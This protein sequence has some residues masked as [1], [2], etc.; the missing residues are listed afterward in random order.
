MS[1]VIVRL[2]PALA[3]IRDRGYSAGMRR[4]WL[5][6]GCMSFALVV[7]AGCESPPTSSNATRLEFEVVHADL[8][9][10]ADACGMRGRIFAVGRDAAGLGLVLE[11]TVTGLTAAT[12]E[13]PLPPL[14]ACWQASDSSLFAVGKSLVME[15]NP[16]GEWR[17]HD[18]SERFEGQIELHDVEGWDDGGVIVAGSVDGRGA[19]FRS[20]DGAWSMVDLGEIS[21]PPLLSMT[22]DVE[23]TIYAVGSSGALRYPREGSLVQ[24][25]APTQRLTSVSS[26]GEEIVAVTYDGLILQRAGSELTSLNELGARFLCTTF[27]AD[28]TLWIAGEGGVII[29][30]SRS[31][32]ST[33]NATPQVAETP[34]ALDVN[35]LLAGRDGPWALAETTAGSQ[36][37][38][39]IGNE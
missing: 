13:V 24:L 35:A 22:I 6:L 8:P 30:H 1:L 33:L 9:P 7:C 20:D 28:G 15:R 37:W 5:F 31:R 2:V 11:E 38:R 18:L 29:R 14:R 3:S 34:E 10:L 39:L 4:W 32:T 36:I 26:F 17:A 23:G 25:A 27:T 16:Q 21:V 12:F 19:L